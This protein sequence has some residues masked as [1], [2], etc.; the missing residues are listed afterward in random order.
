[1]NKRVPIGKEVIGFKVGYDKESNNITRLGF[2]LWTPNPSDEARRTDEKLKL[3]TRNK[4][5]KGYN[6]KDKDALIMVTNL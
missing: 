3:L 5:M 6:H 2:L 1:M 4:Q